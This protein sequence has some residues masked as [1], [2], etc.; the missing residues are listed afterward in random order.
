MRRVHI[1]KRSH[2]KPHANAGLCVGERAM[3]KEGGLSSH[4]CWIKSARVMFAMA[5][6]NRRHVHLLFCSKGLCQAA[7]DICTRFHAAGQ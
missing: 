3:R 2:A 6:V 4:K 1:S 7:V 5:M